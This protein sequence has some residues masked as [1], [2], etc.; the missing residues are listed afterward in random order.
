M[1]MTAAKPAMPYRSTETM[2]A[3]WLVYDVGLAVL[4]ILL[5]TEALNRFGIASPLWAIVYAMTLLRI[6]FVL[7]A[8]V[9]VLA[10]NALLF[11]YPAVC[12]LSVVWS[13]ERGISMASALQL[14]ATIVIA[15]F[16]GAR[17]KLRSIILFVFIVVGATAFLSLVN[18]ATG[19]F[20]TVYAGSG[21]LLGIYSQK[22]ALGQRCLI[23]LLAGFAILLTPGRTSIVLRAFVLGTVLIMLVALALSKSAT[24]NILVVP[25]AAALVFLCAHRLNQGFFAITVLLGVVAL[26]TIPLTLALLDLNPVTLILKAFGKDAS[27]TGRTSIW[28]IGEAVLSK[29]FSLGVGYLAFWRSSE[30]ASLALL[31]QHIGGEAVMGFHNFILE[32]WVGTGLPGLMGIGLLIVVALYR[33]GLLYLRTRDVSAAYGAIAIGVSIVLALLGTSL[34]R[35]H[36]FSMLL[37]T[38]LAVSAGEE[39]RR[40]RRARANARSS[41]GDVPL[42]PTGR[43]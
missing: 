33:T 3:L 25:F 29:H 6:A 2:A 7:N 8:F 17:F 36:E 28:D 21:G 27:L 12:L 42:V 39:L 32:I 31:A 18:W 10:R 1:Q 24:S 26:G 22:N 41:D 30:F 4:A 37:I 38:M 19:I 23:A 15:T 14:L 20:G 13:V 9:G 34:Y 35:Q 5:A 40:F 16:I 43:P 11:V